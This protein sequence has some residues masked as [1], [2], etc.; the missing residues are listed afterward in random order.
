MELDV[1]QL[2]ENAVREQEEHAR[3]IAELQAQVQQLQQPVI[4]DDEDSDEELDVREE[5]HQ[6]REQFQQQAWEDHQLREQAAL[7]REEQARHLTEL[8]EKV[9]DDPLAPSCEPACNPSTAC[10]PAKLSARESSCVL[11][12]QHPRSQPVTEG[13]C[14][15]RCSS[16]RGKTTSCGR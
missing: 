12:A 11:V 14:E 9:R 7:E 16:R 4:D 10:R 6:L 8:Q 13:V 2:R 1:Q 3:L 5:L 15:S